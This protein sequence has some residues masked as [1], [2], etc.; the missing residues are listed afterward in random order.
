VRVDLFAD[1]DDS[2]AVRRAVDALL[3]LVAGEA[4]A[5]DVGGDQGTGAAGRPV[6][7]LLFWVAADDVGAAART[8]VDTAARA[9]A[10][11]GAAG[12]PELYDVT[13]IPA[14]AVVRPGDPGYP[15]MPD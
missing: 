7:G 10:A 6:V 4:E 12:E 13:V 15:P 3:A 5:G 8:A 14:A 2:D 1:R 11:T 9:L